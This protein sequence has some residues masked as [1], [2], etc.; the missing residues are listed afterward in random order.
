L[1]GGI[2]SK[3]ERA[4]LD[5]WFDTA[6][7][8]SDLAE[9]RGMCATLALRITECMI[10]GQRSS[11]ST[12]G[13]SLSFGVVYRSAQNLCEAP[14]TL[15]AAI[16]AYGSVVTHAGGEQ[17]G[18]HTRREWRGLTIRV[19]GW[20]LI[21]GDRNEPGRGATACL[22]SGVPLDDLVCGEN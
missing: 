8:A 13:C 7:E 4:N 10:G 11:S 22:M 2:R 15:T 21:G 6:L 19:L 17:E 20:R 1:E 14:T 5:A 3:R 12:A 16:Q 9:F 18:C